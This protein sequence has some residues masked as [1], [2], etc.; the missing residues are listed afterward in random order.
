M[1]SEYTY[2][3]IRQRFCWQ[4]MSTDVKKVVDA[5]VTCAERDYSFRI[6]DGESDGKISQSHRRHCH[7]VHGSPINKGGDYRPIRKITA[8][9]AVEDGDS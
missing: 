2:R 8:I 6:A 7:I 3:V 4:S 5:C 1:R 9:C